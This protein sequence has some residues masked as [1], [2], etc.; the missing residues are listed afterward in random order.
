[1]DLRV[2]SL[3]LLF[4]VVSPGSFVELPQQADELFFFRIGQSGK[5]P[6]QTFVSLVSEFCRPRFA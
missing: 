4:R 6:V 1:M 3:A 2:F 5:S